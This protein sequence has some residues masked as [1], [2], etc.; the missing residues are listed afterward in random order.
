[1]SNASAI[2]QI[3][4]LPVE[5]SALIQSSLEL[6]PGVPASEENL[7]TLLAHIVEA[8][9]FI[10]GGAMRSI[11]QPSVEYRV[12]KRKNAR[13]EVKVVTAFIPDTGPNFY[14]QPV[15]FEQRYDPT[16]AG[17]LNAFVDVKSTI[18]D[19]TIRGTCPDCAIDEPF[20]KRRRLNLKAPGMPK[21]CKCMLSSIVGL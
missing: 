10:A 17:L 19:L 9:V 1:M 4:S 13:L 6:S 12:N 8:E 2:P 16:T 18:S 11:D 14:T 5:V 21:C 3:A 20:A 15:V 7:K